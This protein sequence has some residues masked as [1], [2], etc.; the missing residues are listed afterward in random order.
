MRIYLNIVILTVLL[1]CNK[2]ETNKNHYVDITYELQTNDSI[3][4]SLKYGNFYELSN[5][6]SGVIMEDWQVTGTGNFN[7]T[8][9]MRKGFVADVLGIHSAS[10]DWSLK[11]K[12]AS[13]TVLASG[14]PAFNADSNYYYLRI[15]APAQ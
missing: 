13:G 7:K 3:F 5:G 11:I 1:A 14:I 8:V 2:S 10:D 15:T 6:F 9:S 12:S 4:A